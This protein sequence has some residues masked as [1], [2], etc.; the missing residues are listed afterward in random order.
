MK[1]LRRGPAFMRPAAR[2]GGKL[3]PNREREYYHVE[4]ADRRFGIGESDEPRLRWLRYAINVD[5]E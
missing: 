1:P 4:R 5:I 3:F 2:E